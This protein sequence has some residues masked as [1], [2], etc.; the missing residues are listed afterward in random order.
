MIKFDQ[1]L[2]TEKSEDENMRSPNFFDFCARQHADPNFCERN[3]RALIN[4]ERANVQLLANSELLDAYAHPEEFEFQP[5][6]Q[7]FDESSELATEIILAHL[8]GLKFL[9][10]FDTFLHKNRIDS[11]KNFDKEGTNLEAEIHALKELFEQN[12][13][14]QMQHLNLIAQQKEDILPS[15]ANAAENTLNTFESIEAYIKNPDNL[16]NSLVFEEIDGKF[17]DELSN[18]LHEIRKD[19]ENR[20]EDNKHNDYLHLDGEDIQIPS[21]KKKNKKTIKKK[22]GK[23]ILYIYSIFSVDFHQ[24]LINGIKFNDTIFRPTQEI[25]STTRNR[26]QEIDRGLFSERNHNWNWHEVGESQAIV[27]L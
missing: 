18:L 19:E 11:T 10:I 23:V 6:L 16:F 8:I 27:L 26:V 21:S 17:Y 15:I 14:K 25:L 24:K 9:I 22:R 1:W 7:M 13:E 4:E 12:I 20:S 5:K 2:N 3:F